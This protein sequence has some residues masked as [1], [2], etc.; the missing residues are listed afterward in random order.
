MGIIHPKYLLGFV[1]TSLLT[2]TSFS[3]NDEESQFKFGYELLLEGKYDLAMEVF[4]P[5]SSHNQDFEYRAEAAYYFA[6]SAKNAGYFYQA[7]QMMIHSVTQFQDWENLENSYLLLTE[8]Y[9]LQGDYQNALANLRNLSSE[10]NQRK[11]REM[12]VSFLKK[13]NDTDSLKNLYYTFPE[14][15]DVGLILSEKISTP[16]FEPGDEMLLENIIG[17]FKLDPERFNMASRRIYMKDAY[18]VAVLLPFKWK[19]TQTNNQ[20]FKNKF[21][22]SIYSGILRAA[23]TLNGLGIPILIRPYDTEQSSF[24]V[25]EILKDSSLALADLIIGPMYPHLSRTVMEYGRQM[26]INVINP[27]SKNMDLIEGNPYG[28][29]FQVPVEISS[30]RLSKLAYDSSWYDSASYPGVIINDWEKDSTLLES[31][32]GEFKTD[33]AFDLDSILMFDPS[34]L[35]QVTN[36]IHR[37]TLDSISISHIFIPSNHKA[38]ASRVLSSADRVDGNFPILGH[39]AW[40]EYSNISLEQLERRRV[41][42]VYSD[43]IKWNSDLFWLLQ[44]EPKFDPKPDYYTC[45]GYE[46]LYFFGKVLNDHGRFFQEGLIRDGARSGFFYPGFDY[47][48]GNYNSFTPIVRVRNNRL[49]WINRWELFSRRN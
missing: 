34:D 18:N 36:Y 15:R 10:D 20:Y 46:I 2:T 33:T 44:K 19:L 27:L 21:A 9:F 42:F 47:S 38:L 32:I 13:L 25:E 35:E 4:K 7:R 6:V 22:Y 24:V 29:L 28:Y 5:L 12:K 11:G 14:D 26:R 37:D 39:S 23:D 3:Q 16:P 17:F 40:V 8:I 41:F 49:D 45:L 1:L 31:Y 43:W 30:L 48:K